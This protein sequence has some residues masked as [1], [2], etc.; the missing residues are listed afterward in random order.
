MEGKDMSAR[1]GSASDGRGRAREEMDGHGGVGESTEDERYVTYDAVFDSEDDET[2]E[3]SRVEV[4]RDVVDAS[5]EDE[6]RARGQ[7]A[8]AAEFRLTCPDKTG[9]GAD[10]CRVAFEFGLVVTRGDFSTDGVWALVLLTVRA[11]KVRAGDVRVVGRG[12]G[13]GDEDED[14]SASASARAVRTSRRAVRRATSAVSW[15]YGKVMAAVNAARGRGSEKASAPGRRGAA[16]GE[17]ALKSKIKRYTS[18]GSCHGENAALM[19]MTQMHR[20]CVVDWELLRQRL[21]LLCPHKSTIS[22]IP[23]VDSLVKLEQTHSQNMYILQ[24][25]CLDRVG[26]LHD[27]TLALWELQ[28]T[29]HRA[30]VTTSPSGKAVDLFYVTDDL[31]ELPNPARVG[32]ISRYVRP[33]VGSTDDDRKRVNIL[34]HPAPSFV[35]RQSRTKTLR[36]SDGMI[37]TEANPSIFQAETTVEIDNLMSPAHTVFQIRTRDRQGLLYDCLRVS[38]DLKVSVSYAKIEIIDRSRCEIALFTRNIKDTAQ[39]KYLC[40]KY[41]EHVDHPL[42]VEMLCNHDESL[43]SELRVVAPLDIAG[44]T[45]PRVLLDVTEALQHL[46][47]MIFKADILIDPRTV[48]N[49]IQDEVHRFLLTDRRGE[50]I[51]TPEARQEVCDRVLFSLMRS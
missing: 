8:P 29:V 36:E 25:E 18:E 13:R 46:D 38:K 6:R 50:P 42:K 41:E 4:E 2:E 11:G 24:V 23:S 15:A 47:V 51:S 28:L 21:E 44:H 34:V 45:R 30:H 10:I 35:T 26:L 19:G 16:S 9:L 27:V 14:A 33:I 49:V 39:M 1:A 31:H 20:S 7:G 43:T 3:T 48:D 37:V 12:R 22:T 40:A 32:D 17:A 5:D